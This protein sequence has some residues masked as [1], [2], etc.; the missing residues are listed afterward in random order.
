MNENLIGKRFNRLLVTSSVSAGKLNVTCDCGKKFIIERNL[1]T[2]NKSCGCLM[3]ESRKAFG[4]GMRIH[5]GT[6]EPHLLRTYRA[7]VSMKS[8]CLRPQAESYYLYG[9]RGITICERWM[10]FENFAADIGEMKE[11]ISLDRIDNSKGYEPGN[12][13]LSTMKQQQN[14]RSNNRRITYQGRTQTMKQWSEEIG[15]DYRLL[16]N[17]IRRG[18][19]FELA[20]SSSQRLA[21]ATAPS[22]RR[23]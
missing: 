15:I 13:R 7:W 18:V 23:S 22:R 9:G 2:R 12:V 20:I 19:P 1:L 4:K 8:R 5:G 17:R 21:T 6:V 3:R 11:G 16:G 10:T 14:N